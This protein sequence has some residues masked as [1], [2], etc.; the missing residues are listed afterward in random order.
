MTRGIE[1]NDLTLKQSAVFG[2]PFSGNL[3]DVQIR[4]RETHYDYNGSTIND[5]ASRID[6]LLTEQLYKIKDRYS[7]DMVFGLG[8]SGG[9]DSRIILHYALKVGIKPLFYFYGDKRYRPFL[10]NLSYLSACKIAKTYNMKPPIVIPFHKLPDIDFFNR[11]CKYNPLIAYNMWELHI[12][13]EEH[14]RFDVQL[15][16][17][18]GGEILGRC[19]VNMRVENQ[20]DFIDMI[21]KRFASHH[22]P[23]SYPGV[24][25]DDDYQQMRG[26]LLEFINRFD[27]FFSAWQS[28]MCGFFPRA[29]VTG[30]YKYASHFSP[31]VEAPF[32]SYEFKKESETWDTRWLQSDTMKLQNYFLNKHLPVLSRIP[33]Q[34]YLP[35]R[36]WYANGKEPNWFIK[37]WFW[38]WRYLRGPMASY[39]DVFHSDEFRK[40]AFSVLDTPHVYFDSLFDVD[41]IKKMPKRFYSNGGFLPNLVKIKNMFLQGGHH[42]KCRLNERTNNMELRDRRTWKTY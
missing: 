16:G 29:F 19:G 28:I 36:H 14:P 6:T 38:Y 40:F 12:Y 30:T 39:T 2:R 15:S 10:Y 22:S 13:D 17:V 23:V 20:S 37:K 42:V 8:L 24:F 32:T 34:D 4:C 11:D 18:N 31:I 33:A 9:L 1:M 3:N 27:D 25:S 5:A 35:P 26:H 41:V 21:F 7:D